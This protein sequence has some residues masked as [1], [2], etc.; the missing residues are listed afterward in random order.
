MKDAMLATYLDYPIDWEG[1]H[2]NAAAIDRTV[3]PY[4]YQSRGPELQY[5]REDGSGPLSLLAF[6]GVDERARLAVDPGLEPLWMLM[7]ASDPSMKVRQAVRANPE[8]V[9][10]VKLARANGIDIPYQYDEGDLSGSTELEWNH[11]YGATG[12]FALEE[13]ARLGPLDPVQNYLL[14]SAYFQERRYCEAKPL[15]VRWVE[16]SDGSEHPVGLTLLAVCMARL[17]DIS[18]GSVIQER[19]LAAG[20]D[21]ETAKEFALAL[22]ETGHREDAARWY[23]RIA[24]AGEPSAWDV[25]V[26]IYLEDQNLREAER[27]AKEAASVAHPDGL[28]RVGRYY[29][30]QASSTSDPIAFVNSTRQ[31]AVWIVSA[32][33]AGD[34]AA[35]DFLE[36]QPTYRRLGGAST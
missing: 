25:L 21:P 1:H 26:D 11:F 17:G 32:A 16:S 28:I 22:L 20:G 34:P 12:K 14:G 5:W 30:V 23:L 36:K 29:L 35:I 31:A 33:E 9:E 18:S 19:A 13:R 4:G 8:W 24:R 6:L 15:L 7:I 27:T 3:P 2:A 10:A